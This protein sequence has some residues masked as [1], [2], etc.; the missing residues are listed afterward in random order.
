MN[1]KKFLKLAYLF[2]KIGDYKN[3]DIAL[4]VVVSQIDNPDEDLLGISDIQ[5]TIKKDPVIE[6]LNQMVKSGE[7]SEAQFW[8]AVEKYKP[9]F[10]SNAINKAGKP[11]DYHLD[12]MERNISS[13]GVKVDPKERDIFA[14]FYEL[15]SEVFV[16]FISS[17]EADFASSLRTMARKNELPEMFQDINDHRAGNLIMDLI[18][19]SSKEELLT[20]EYLEIKAKGISLNDVIEIGTDGDFSDI[21]EYLKS[22][23]MD[24]APSIAAKA[25]RMTGLKYHPED[26]ERKI[27]DVTVNTVNEIIDNAL[28]ELYYIYKG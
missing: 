24:L 21:N 25:S 12:R 27:Q 5:P 16:D 17:L 11:D 10:F 19:P 6:K 20:R 18:E 22:F 13:Q 4:K 8:V 1:S 26:L 9:G 2:D 15:S 7:I 28:T 14:Q 3:S 23:V